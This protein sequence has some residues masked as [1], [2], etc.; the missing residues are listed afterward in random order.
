MPWDA[1][2]LFDDDNDDD[3]EMASIKSR[4]SRHGSSSEASRPPTSKS[5]GVFDVNDDN[6][7]DNEFL[8][9]VSAPSLKSKQPKPA[10]VNTCI[11]SPLFQR[12]SKRDVVL[13]GEV[14]STCLIVISY[15][16]HLQIS[17]T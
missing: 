9:Q 13:K 2:S 14:S 5:E 17:D 11:I 16:I 6:D 15:I 3:I 1:A 10:Q 8:P 12:V 7:N 4:H